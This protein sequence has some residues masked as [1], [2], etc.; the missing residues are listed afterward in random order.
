MAAA[1]IGLLDWEPPYAMEVALEKAERQNNNNNNNNN[2]QN[3]FTH[4]FF[5]VL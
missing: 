3:I 5:T 2:N 4:K 1:P